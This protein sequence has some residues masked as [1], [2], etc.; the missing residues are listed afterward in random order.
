MLPRMSTPSPADAPAPAPAPAERLAAAG[1]PLEAPPDAPRPARWADRLTLL[2]LFGA[3]CTLTAVATPAVLRAAGV[4]AQA[5]PVL[6]AKKLPRPERAEPS[7]SREPAFLF[8]MDDEDDDR[9]SPHTWPPRRSTDRAGGDPLAAP[10]APEDEGT[11]RMG[12]ARRPLRLLGNPKPDGEVLGEVE[13]GS[14]VMIMKE[15][16]DWALVVRTGQEG[17]VMGWARRSEIA[18]R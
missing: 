18:V 16:G 15:A 3:L 1:S 8:D 6:R 4:G 7:P 13:A 11:V 2:L 17:V 5:A 14:S 10:A 12:L 9:R